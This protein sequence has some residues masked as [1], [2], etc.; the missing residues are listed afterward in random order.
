MMPEMDGNTLCTKIKNKVNTN[1]IPVILL[2]AMSREEDQLT[3]LQSGADA[4]LV[5]A[6]AHSAP[7]IISATPTACVESD[8]CSNATRS[9]TG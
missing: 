9:G 6:L 4:Y 2:T 1:H 3:G 7:S 5:R 8:G